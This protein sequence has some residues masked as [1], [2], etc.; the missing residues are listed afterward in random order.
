MVRVLF[1]LLELLAASALMASTAVAHRQLE[2]LRATRDE[3][4]S[5]NDWRKALLAQADLDAAERNASFRLLL[6]AVLALSIYVRI[7]S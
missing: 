4:W 3:A 1:Q 7:R 2:V 5:G 6:A